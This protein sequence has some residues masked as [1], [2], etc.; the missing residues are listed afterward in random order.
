[1]AE[2][3]QPEEPAQRRFYGHYLEWHFA[4]ITNEQVRVHKSKVTRVA[5][6]GD[7]WQV[8]APAAT[9][10]VDT[11]VLALGHVVAAAPPDAQVLLD[12]AKGKDALHILPGNAADVI[13]AAILG[14]A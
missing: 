6:F 12:Y 2:S 4:S 9:V 10:R 11:V 3:L 1:L 13:A 5:P 7:Q 14:V 8:E